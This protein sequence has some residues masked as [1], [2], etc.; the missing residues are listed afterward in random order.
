M[1]YLKFN[2]TYEDRLLK[3]ELFCKHLT[4]VDN[5]NHRCIKCVGNTGKNT[6]VNWLK[7]NCISVEKPFIRRSKICMGTAKSIF[8]QNQRSKHFS[9]AIYLP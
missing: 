8:L 5:V 6:A 4:A 9:S 2:G 3:C 7:T 1:T